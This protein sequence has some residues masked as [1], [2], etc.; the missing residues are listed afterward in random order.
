MP[1]E[2]NNWIFCHMPKTGG[3]S[4]I[5]Y[6]KETWGGKDRWPLLHGHAPASDVPYHDLKGKTLIGT[7]RDP[8]GWYA[9]WWM[10][11]LANPRCHPSLSQYG[12]GSCEF[13]AVLK[14]VTGPDK[15]LVPES[16]GVIWSVNMKAGVARRTLAQSGKGL[17]SWTFNHVYGNNVKELARLS[18]L[19]GDLGKILG[20]E[21]SPEEMPP[22]N[23]HQERGS[24][25]PVWTDEMV[26][27]VWQAD[28]ELIQ[29]LG[30]EPP[31]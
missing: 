18:N 15:S 13:S 6:L 1:I 11:A 23:T 2:A 4:V 12:Q 20:A 24:T 14:G 16:P 21:I 26:E 22:S 30:F 28:A 10:H 9:S 5:N 25:P 19:R 29:R 7:I 27:M 3:T 31:S 17:Y 8:W